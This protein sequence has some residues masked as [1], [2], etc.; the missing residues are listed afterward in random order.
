[1][2]GIHDLGGKH[3]YGKVEREANEPVFHGRWEAAV[4]SF[5]AAS[6]RAGALNCA[7]RFRH[8]I[9]R[10]DPV[11][12]LSH[13]YYGRWLGGI[14]TLL[15]EAGVIDPEEL[16]NR[17]IERGADERD[18]IA[19]RPREHPDPLGAVPGAP[20]AERDTDAGPRFQIGDVVVTSTEVKPGHTR[21]PAYARGKE[22]TV[23]SRHGGWVFPDTSAHGL[24]EN[25][26]HLYTVKFAGEELWGTGADPRLSVHLDL[27]EPYLSLAEE[28]P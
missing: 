6:I 2:D 12:Y 14:E 20:T 4:F 19:A 11:A 28:R 21:L 10:I 3:G 18:L 24:G 25:P 16:T 23:V 26:T 5:V 7:D 9:E 22:G 8:A 27:F 13:G 15:V 17:A 1:M